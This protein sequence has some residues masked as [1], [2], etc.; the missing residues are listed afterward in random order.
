[1]LPLLSVAQFAP[2]AGQEGST[3]IHADS[4][5]IVAWATGCV[6]ERGPMRIDQPESGLASYGVDDDG[7][8]KADGLHVVSLGDG[9]NA[10]L[11]FESPISNGPGYDFAVFENAFKWA[12]DTTLYFLE[13]AFVEVSSDGVNYVRF[14][15]V[16]N[17][18]TE[19]QCG[20]FECTD[21]RLFHNLAGKYASLYGTPFDLD[22][23]PDD[24]LLD[25][26]HVTHVRIVD[27]VGTLLPEYATY[28][29]E[30]H[31]V[32]DPWPTPFNSS[33]FDLDAVGVL[34]DQSH[35]GVHEA[36]TLSLSV[37]PNPASETL[38]VD[39][40]AELVSLYT[41]TGQKLMETRQH[42]MDVSQLNPGLYVARIAAKEKTIITKFVK[43]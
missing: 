15:A 8:G 3:A 16:S 31:V 38:F 32:N 27:V 7:I 2:P 29:S 1:M 10:V 22:E 26:N 25:K 4:A 30:G 36:E 24:P 41:L 21:P 12:V 28:D 9:G 18:Q 19:V 40:P 35:L 34:H 33:G 20:S 17:Y 11:T 5:A 6:V 42:K 43:K 14:P 23:L 39:G 37:Y 13:L